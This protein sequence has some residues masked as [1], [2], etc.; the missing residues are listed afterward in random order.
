M[1]TAEDG[2]WLQMP[3][4]SKGG[5]IPQ[6]GGPPTD[7]QVFSQTWR[8]FHIEVQSKLCGQQPLPLLLLP[9]NNYHQERFHCT[10]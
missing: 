4:L 2:S 3:F 7:P 5:G 1:S 10:S 6:Y 9:Q 8:L